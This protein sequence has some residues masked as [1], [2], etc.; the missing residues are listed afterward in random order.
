MFAILKYLP[1]IIFGFKDVSNEY[2]E[3]TGENRPWYLSRTF[4]YSALCFVGTL[5]TIGTGIELEKEKIKA[6]ADNVTVII[7]AVIALVSA[8][9]SF[10]AQFKRKPTETKSDTPS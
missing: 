1:K 8:V 4:L 3:V 10:I 7:P 5:V 9:M 2:K 6:I